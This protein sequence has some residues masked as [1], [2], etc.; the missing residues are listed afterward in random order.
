MTP[1]ARATRTLALVAGLG[2][3]TGPM[4]QAVGFTMQAAEAKVQIPGSTVKAAGATAQAP[5]AQAAGAIDGTYAGSF[6]GGRG[7]VVL[8]GLP[9][10]KVS[11]AIQVDTATGLAAMTGTAFVQGSRLVV[12]S[13]KEGHA[14]R[15]DLVS[16]GHTVSVAETSCALDHGAAV[17]FNGVAFKK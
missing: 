4:A 7:T 15:I 11:V 5:G 16:D 17:S 2:I 8:L 10:G 1:L 3:S 14:C 6:E 13:D 12:T 9:G